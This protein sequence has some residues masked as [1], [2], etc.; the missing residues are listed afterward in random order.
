[1]SFVKEPFAM[2]VDEAYGRGEDDADA[3][4]QIHKGKPVFISQRQD[5]ST[6]NDS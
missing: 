5:R 3:Q 6:F 2:K 4:V 1:M